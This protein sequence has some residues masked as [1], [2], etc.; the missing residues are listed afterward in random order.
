[1]WIGF[2]P[3]ALD[4]VLRRLQR[5]EAVPFRREPGE[6]PLRRLGAL[7]AHGGEALAVGGEAVIG[8]VERRKDG[9]QDRGARPLVGHPEEGPGALAMPLH[10]LS[11]DE[12]LQ[13]A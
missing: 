7:A 10:E 4:E 2:D 12:Q 3:S 13:V 8:T 6:E 9:A 5:A 11:V 1:L